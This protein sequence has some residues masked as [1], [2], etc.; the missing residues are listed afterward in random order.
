M[1]KPS[2]NEVLDKIDNEL[3]VNCCKRAEEIITVQKLML[4]LKIE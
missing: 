1:L 2:I 3:L 4:Q